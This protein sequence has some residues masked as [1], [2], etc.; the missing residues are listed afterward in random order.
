MK[1]TI[2]VTFKDERRGK[3][4]DLYYCSETEKVYIRQE[5]DNDH[6]KW[7]TAIPWVG[8]YEADCHMK[9]GLLIQV[10]DQSGSILF[11]ENL[12]EEE[13]VT[14]TWAPKKGPFSWESIAALE[15]EY[16]RALVLKT[17]EEWKD[18]LMTDAKRCGFKS[19]SEN[20][21]YAMAEYGPLT[22]IARVSYLGVTAYV[23]VHAAKHKVCG[24]NWLCYEL[25][26]A[27]LDTT[28]AL[29]GYKFVDGGNLPD[30]IQRGENC[31]E[32]EKHK[33]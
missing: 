18:W 1:S 28:L 31:D 13:G 6:V 8:G 20:W 26:D 14:G 24:K 17:Y 5:Y 21:L 16:S 23:A 30:T 4:Q 11:A 32:P 22:E 7:L 10:T 15:E 3:G 9:A 29:C 25:K 19:C 27:D 33:G 2:T 12:L